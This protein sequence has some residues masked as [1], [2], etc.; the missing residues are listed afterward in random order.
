MSIWYSV[1]HTHVQSGQVCQLAFCVSMGTEVTLLSLPV[2]FRKC[3]LLW[4]GLGHQLRSDNASMLKGIKESC[5]VQVVVDF[6]AELC[7]VVKHESVGTKQKK[8]RGWEW[9]ARL[10]GHL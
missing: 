2:Y 5:I 10:M 3:Y 8:S 4:L 6:I 1:Q 9:F 7:F